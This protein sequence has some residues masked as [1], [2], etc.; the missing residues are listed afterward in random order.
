LGGGAMLPVVI[1]SV[2]LAVMMV[3]V[4]VHQYRGY[5]PRGRHVAASPTREVRRGR[6]VPKHAMY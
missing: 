3:A 2:L 5:T 1:F 4:V 6:R